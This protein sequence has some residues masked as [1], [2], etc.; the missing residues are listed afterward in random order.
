MTE[1]AARTG[2]L[3][4][5]LQP[6]P[7]DGEYSLEHPKQGGGRQSRAAHIARPAPAYL[8]SARRT[9]GRR[10]SACDYTVNIA[11]LCSAR[12][13]PLLLLLAILSEIETSLGWCPPWICARSLKQDQSEP[14]PVINQWQALDAAIATANAWCGT[15]DHILMRLQ[16]VWKSVIETACCFR[17]IHGVQCQYLF[18]YL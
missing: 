9:V 13:L 1:P 6:L 11:R 8:G 12:C 17:F 5:S 7:E 18:E 3:S 15:R 14:R 16:P 2:M 10:L 4:G